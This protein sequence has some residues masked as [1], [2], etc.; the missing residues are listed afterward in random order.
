MEMEDWLCD[1][2]EE[3]RKGGELLEG[4]CFGGEE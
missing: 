4:L 1:C 3:G 2:E